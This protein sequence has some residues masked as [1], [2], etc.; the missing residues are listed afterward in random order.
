MFKY[1]YDKRIVTLKRRVKE[2]ETELKSVNEKNALS[3]IYSKKDTLEQEGI[4]KLL[5][6][7]VNDI[8][9]LFSSSNIIV[10]ISP[11]CYTHLGYL[12]EEME[13]KHALTFVHP[14][15]QAMLGELMNQPDYNLSL[16]IRSHR[17]VHKDGSTVWV[18]SHWKPI[19]LEYNGQQTQAVYSTKILGRI[20]E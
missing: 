16:P 5:L 20:N 8:V 9:T 3:V 17:L 12:P 11:S 10:Y 2:L 4:F 7:N 1:F 13:G 15:D 14:D 6:D 18:E 19:Y